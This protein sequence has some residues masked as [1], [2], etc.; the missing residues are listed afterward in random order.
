MLEIVED[1][2]HPALSEIGCDPLFHRRAGLFLDIQRLRNHREQQAWLG[3]RYQVDKVDAIGEARQRLSSHLKGQTSLA[4][5]TRSGER[6]QAN[7][8]KQLQDRIDGVL[9]P[10]TTGQLSWR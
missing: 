4:R 1:Q 3:D 6:Q 10:D 8:T 7:P 2:Q 5:S 9:A